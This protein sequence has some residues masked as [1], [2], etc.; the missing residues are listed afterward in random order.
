MELRSP[1][2]RLAIVATLL[3]LWSGAA[4]GRLAYLQL[5]RYGDYL[6]RAERQQQ[7]IV[8]I[9][10]KR[11]DILDRNVR[12][13]AMSATVDS[14]FAIPSEIADPG[15]VAT[16]LARVLNASPDD[17]ATRL[18]SS[19]SFVWV[20]RKLPPQTAAR[21]AALN[22]RGIYFQREDQRFYPNRELAAPLLGYVDIDEHGLAGVEYQLDDRIRSKPGRMMILADA[23][24][25]WYDSSDKRPELGSS[26]V[27]TIDQNIQ[28][29]AE[30]ELDAAITQT[31]AKAGT[32]IVQDPS[33]G[34]ILAMAS[35]PTFNPNAVAES[36]PESRMNRA[37][38]ALYEPGSVFKIVTLSAAID[39]GITTAD[40]LVDCQMGAIYIAGHR[41]RD[42]H[43]FGVLTVSQILA[44]SSDVGAIKIG[45]RLGAPKLYDYIRAYGFGSPS[46]IDLPGEN[47]GL[48]RRLE[49]W[50]PVS[51]GAVSM[52]QEVGVTPVQMITAVSAIA[53]GGLLYRP[54]VVL[55]LRKASEEFASPESGPRRVV[56]ATTAATMRAMLEGVVLQGTGKL[57]QLDGYTAAGKTGTAQKIDPATGRY[58]ATQLI[59]SFVGFAPINNP[60]ITV[61]VQLDSPVGAH[62]GGSVAAPVFRRI[63]EQVLAYRN[64]PHDVALPGNALRASHPPQTA[65]TPED[66]ADFNP[67][68]DESLY[69]NADYSPDAPS[70]S[71]LHSSLNTSSNSPPNRAAG[72]PANGPANNLARI[73]TAG[74]A[75]RESREPLGL[76]QTPITSKSAS[77]LPMSPSGSV[78]AVPQNLPVS[79]PT[80]ELA[81]G[82]SVSLPSLTGKTV[83]EVMETCQ[84][85]GLNPVLVG[86]GVAQEQEPEAGTSMRRGGA[87]T[88]R[89]GRTQEV[90]QLARAR[91]GGR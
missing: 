65:V 32:V 42:H 64:V 1:L 51:I 69:R 8:E 28:F 47:R 66:V 16:L 24:S 15:M 57:A 43:P 7:H 70:N 13:L 80:V 4:V 61:L 46:G 75:N 17:I 37:V 85:L 67:V 83:R 49:N 82:A 22:L 60:A 38:G 56:R 87:V 86:S 39:Q 23:H 40:E 12:E 58:S 36:S 26:V 55:T 77:G 10:P 81:D 78:N 45:L 89:F 50:T 14:C 53:N 84:Q 11:A 2:T 63:A 35:W 31:Q 33:N 62:E 52:G 79:L 72:S 30:K 59:A 6:A 25:R 68:Q 71:S 18:A 91:K 5:F 48:L 76:A 74:P 44:H 9:S 29:I 27:L 88:V 3:V 73:L 20:A 90:A 21:I 34:E 54:H 41:I 19:H